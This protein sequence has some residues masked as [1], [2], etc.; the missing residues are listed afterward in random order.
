MCC[1]SHVICNV[2][3]NPSAC[4][5]PLQFKKLGLVDISKLFK[6]ARLICG[7]YQK[8]MKIKSILRSEVVLRIFNV[9]G[10]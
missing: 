9:Y 6:V 1:N 7:G 3:K 2:F 4:Y 5:V 8:S 10:L